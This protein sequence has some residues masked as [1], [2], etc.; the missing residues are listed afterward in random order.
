[1]CIWASKQMVPQS[2]LVVCI[3]PTFIQMQ[4]CDNIVQKS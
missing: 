3:L 2:I 1:V 4:L